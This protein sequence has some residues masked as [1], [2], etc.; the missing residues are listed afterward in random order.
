MEDIH[1]WIEVLGMIAK[2]NQRPGYEGFWGFLYDWQTLI[3]GVF[4]LAAG[5]FVWLQV[6]QQGHQIQTEKEKHAD[7]MKR[8]ERAARIRIPHALSKL[9]AFYEHSYSAFISN[10][11]FKGEIEPSAVQVLMEVS[12]AIDEISYES[13]NQLVIQTQVFEARHI[14]ADGSHKTSDHLYIID[15]SRLKYLIDRLYDYGRLKSNDP[16]EYIAPDRATLEETLRMA[17]IY[18]NLHHEIQI[19]LSKRISAAFTKQYGVS[20]LA[21]GSDYGN[22]P[23]DFE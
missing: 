16:V 23:L 9:S 19:E 10:T 12:E 11:S 4:A 7:L 15:L 22:E 1:L 3:S 18:Q 20:R 21:E 2:W 13:V 14:N 6:L 8:R 5:A 17:R